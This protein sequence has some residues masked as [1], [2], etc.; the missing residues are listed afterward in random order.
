M[1]ASHRSPM[2]YAPSMPPV[3]AW[4]GDASQWYQAHDASQRSPMGYVFPDSPAVGPP[5]AVPASPM[6]HSMEQTA[7]ASAATTAEDASQQ[8]SA[9]A[10]AAATA[11][12]TG[13]VLAA[14]AAAKA[15]KA[16]GEAAA[17][18]AAAAAVATASA[19]SSQQNSPVNGSQVQMQQTD[20][21]VP[22]G[23][24]TLLQHPIVPV[25]SSTDSGC[26]DVALR[27]W[28]CGL[29][30]MELEA[31]LRAAAPDTYED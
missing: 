13:D 15:A 2:A 16:A 10:A 23:H 25:S 6:P 21:E 1:D 7:S 29:S 30:N 11:A 20:Q 28:L 31:Q 9:A 4:A 24:P 8:A 26:E 17:A 27:T 14:E 19:A 18:A 3:A 12:A 5:T 22:Q